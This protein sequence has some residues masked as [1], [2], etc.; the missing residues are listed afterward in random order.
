MKKFLRYTFTLL[1]V[2]FLLA[3]GIGFFLMHRLAHSNF[4]KTTVANR[5]SGAQYNYVVVGSSR[6]LTTINTVQL[7]AMLSTSGYNFSIDDTG[8]ETHYLMLQHL[9]ACGIRYKTLV[10]AVD[11][12]AAVGAKSPAPSLAINDNDHRF[13]PFINRTYVH[14]YFAARKAHGGRLYTINR[15]LPF[16]GLGYFN[17]ELLWPA[18]MATL[19][20]SRYYR[21]DSSGNFSYPS[22]TNANKLALRSSDTVVLQ[23]K[24]VHLQNIRDFCESNGIQLVMYY[25]PTQGRVLSPTPPQVWLANERFL[26]YC[27]TI[28][29]ADMFY[30]AQHV[31]SKGREKMTRLLAQDAGDWLRLKP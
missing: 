21:S 29:D 23:Y 5:Q 11:I 7:D 15:A 18:V 10:L 17:V 1:L 3:E 28:G 14:Q 8:I 26:N 19:Q 4:Y 25:S 30:D 2:A 24:N 27:S 6:A 22:N 31:N 12:A 20:P 9:K 13:L 16:V